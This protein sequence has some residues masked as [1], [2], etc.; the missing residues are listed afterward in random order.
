MVV[1][2][3]WKGYVDTDQAFADFFDASHT[4]TLRFMPQYPDAYE[5]PFVAENGSGTFGVGMGDYSR[6]TEGYKLYLA[7]GNQSRDFATSLTPGRWYHLALRCTV[8]ATRT[9]KLYLDGVKL[10]PDFVVASGASGL[11]QG[12]LRFGKR[13]SGKKVNGHNAQFFG[14]LDDV[15]IFTRALSV[16]TINDLRNNVPH[17]T[18]NEADLLVG[19]TFNSGSLPAKLARP[20]TYRKAARRVNS[21]ADRNNTKD[22]KL[23]PLPTEQEVMDLPFPLGEAWSVMQG[24]DKQAGSHRGYAAFCWDFIVADEPKGGVYPDGSNGAPFYASAPGKVITVRESASSGTSKYSNYVE[25]EQAPEEICAYLHLRKNSCE[26]VKNNKVTY[27]QKLALT[28][29]TGTGVGNF[30]PHVAVADKPDKTSGFVTFPVAFSDYELRSGTKWKSVSRGMPKTNEVVRIPP[31]PTFG[32]RSLLHT[33]AVARGGNRLDVVATD[34]SGRAW[35]AHWAPKTYVRNWDRWR[36]AL[37]DVAAY[38]T[39]VG[40]VSRDNNKLDIFIAGHN[41]KTYTGAWDLNVSNQQWRGWWNV[42]TGA[43]PPGGIVTG[44]SRAPDKLDIFLVSNNGGVYT[45][46]WDH[47]VA[48]GKWHGWWRIGNLKAKPGS[49]VAAVARDPNKLDIFVAGKDGRTCTAAWDHNVA[50][51]KWRGWWNIQTGRVPTGGTISA[52]SRAPN[53]L[54]IFLVSNDGRVYTA[55]WQHNVAN[56]KWR[57]WW[58]IGNRQAVPGAPVAAV[59]RHPDKLDVFVAGKDGKTYTAAWDQNVANGKWRGWWNILRG[60][61]TPG[62]AVA[63]VSRHPNKLDI[64]IVSTDGRIYTAAWD[65]NVASGKWRGWWRIGA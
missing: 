51:G 27:G 44:V 61:I 28:G 39:P 48:K 13:S 18:G 49:P 64:F 52:V 1:A 56:G 6:G 33:S 21:S 4:I 41:G 24:V 26:V 59:S 37:K 34:V 45:A 60:S 3:S 20:V 30:H 46:A 50:D 40:L 32:T 10:G 16:A 36:P 7:V 54:D 5:G 29:D 14:L 62:S 12:T 23:L 38:N 57:G 63:A 53:K 25:I 22:S 17:L 65:H 55:A 31:T 11:P 15:A 43:V 8:G 35:V 19:Y 47:H 9:F 2:L 58:R 42:L